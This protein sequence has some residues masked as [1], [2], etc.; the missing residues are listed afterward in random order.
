M[1]LRMENNIRFTFKVL[2]ALLF[3]CSTTKHSSS[4]SAI[5]K[6]HVP[7]PVIIADKVFEDL[8]RIG[9][10]RVDPLDYTNFM[11]TLANSDKINA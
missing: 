1:F 11:Y 5:T 10:G 8:R 7:S 9:A 3:L 2:S 4:S 6:L